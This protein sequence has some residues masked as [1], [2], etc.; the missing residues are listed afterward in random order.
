MQKQEVE[1]TN[2][3]L[4]IDLGIK[5]LAIVSNKDASITKFYKNINKT[6]KIRRLEKKL[7]RE[8]RKLSRKLE[9]NIKDHDKIRRPIWKRP[10]RECANIQ[11]QNRVIQF[12]H[13]KLTNIRNNYLHQTTAEIVKTKPSRIVM[14]D[15]NVKGIMK[16]KHLSKAIAQQKIYEFKR[17][18]KY[19]AEMYGIEVVEADRY[20]ASSK[21]CS[22]CG[23]IK[24]DLKLSD[25]I[26]ICPN[27]GA[28]LNRDLNAAINL[29]NYKTA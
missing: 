9:A 23:H 6:A 28:K 7:R 25:R 27:C 2:E 24:K 1:L 12:L 20:Y 10:L 5:D 16:N 17:Q 8:Q 15:L 26:Y 13:K 22:Y 4:G 3:S 19:K 21:T 14:E 11:R 18:I 29:A